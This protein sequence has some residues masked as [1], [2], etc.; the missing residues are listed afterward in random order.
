MHFGYLTGAIGIKSF[1]YVFS[2]RYYCAAWSQPELVYHTRV[3]S[4]VALLKLT[5]G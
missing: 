3:F 5:G 2:W 1:C 4:Y